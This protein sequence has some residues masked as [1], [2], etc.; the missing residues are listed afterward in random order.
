MLPVAQLKM[1]V[2]VSLVL[3]VLSTARFCRAEAD[4]SQ[5]GSM[6]GEST[7]HK[8]G[9]TVGLFA[10]PRVG[11]S[12]PADLLE[13]G[14]LVEQQQQQQQ[15]LGADDYEDYPYRTGLEM[16]KRQGKLVAFPRVGRAGPNRYWS[17]S[18]STGSGL[19]KRA[20]GNSGAAN[21]A[22]WF[23]PRLGK[24]AHVA[25]AEIKGTEVYTPRL[26]RDPEENQIAISSRLADFGRFFHG[27]SFPP[28]N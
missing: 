25:N 28:E 20:S 6:L 18:S 17:S 3:I 21:S 1:L 12:D 26:G 15:Q 4:G 24:R 14:D 23:G 19:Q 13:W 2:Y 9:P 11:R 8:R 16:A 10:F 5:D 27:S 7:R 22:M